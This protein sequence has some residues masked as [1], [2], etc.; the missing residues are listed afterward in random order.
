MSAEQLQIARQLIQQKKYSE[1][2]AILEQLDHPTA[3]QWLD[4]L[5]EIA[6]L[7]QNTVNSLSDQLDNSVIE[8][9]E[10][11]HT[12]EP[13]L[14]SKSALQ[15]PLLITIAFLMFAI[16]VISVVDLIQPSASNAVN[17]NL[18]PVVNAINELETSIKATPQT[19]RT[20]TQTSATAWEYMMVQYSQVR[21]FDGD[22][23]PLEF[24]IFDLLEYTLEFDNGCDVTDSV[25]RSQNFQ[26][27]SYYMNEVGDDGWELISINNT[28][29]SSYSVELF[30]KRQQ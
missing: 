5:D 11:Y 24:V 26:G 25:C 1:A 28:S 27:L 2:R 23:N 3:T 30:F 8:T 10:D 13:Q 16:L 22:D 15:T 20:S 18:D 12:K 9:N 21:S 14:S 17:L 29:S 4:K 19:A 6:P 7:P